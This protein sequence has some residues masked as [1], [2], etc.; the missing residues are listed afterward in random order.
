MWDEIHLFEVRLSNGLKEEKEVVF[1]KTD[2]TKEFSMKLYKYGA[3]K[4]DARSGTQKKKIKTT[5]KGNLADLKKL[6]V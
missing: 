1:Y 5:T 2:F 6:I 4:T 3:L